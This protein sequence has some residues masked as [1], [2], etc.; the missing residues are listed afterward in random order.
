MT[1]VVAMLALDARDD[2]VRVALSALVARGASRVTLAHTTSEAN[3]HI[4]EARLREIGAGL[5][6]A[7]VRVCVRAGTADAVA[8]ALLS[9]EAA[10]LLVIGRMAS[11]DGQS[12]WGDHGRGL[13]RAAGC[14]VLLVPADAEA[15]LRHALVGMD[16]SEAALDALA[17]AVALCT[18]VEALAVL[19]AEDAAGAPDA[20]RAALQARFAAAVAARGLGPVPLRTVV[21]GSPADALLAAAEGVD[22]LAV[23]SRG[24]SPLAAVFL[25][26]TAE[27]LAGKSPRP[28]LVVR[29]RGEARG[30]LGAIFS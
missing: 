5:A 30:L 4:A 29:R 16:L 17:R 13:L 19:S 25:G 23:G 7:A 12:A 26:S 21:G 8:T 18:R 22:L 2:G 10:D 27:R 24:L 15:P 3:A 6:P 9:E 1:S 20:V 11:E 14:P 28:V